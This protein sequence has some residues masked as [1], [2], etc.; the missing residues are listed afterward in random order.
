M[1]ETVDEVLFLHFLMIFFATIAISAIKA[2]VTTAA[3]TILMTRILFP[4]KG[5]LGCC[6]LVAVV[7]VS[8]VVVVVVVAVV[9]VPILF[10]VVAVVVV[11]MRS[12]VVVVFLVVCFDVVVF[13]VV[14]CCAIVVV[15]AAAADTVVAAV[16]VVDI[17][18]LTGALVD[19]VA[20]AVV[21]FVRSPTGA[22]VPKMSGSPVLPSSGLTTGSTVVVVAIS[23]S[24]GSAI[25]RRAKEAYRKIAIFLDEDKR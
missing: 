14:V 8:F 25:K 9:F 10:V 11:V 18:L 22:V 16:A 24:F 19:V 20:V 6:L 23:D 12:L 2:I 1:G 5:L 15:V 21:A 4:V 13:F 7:N 3:P 17:E